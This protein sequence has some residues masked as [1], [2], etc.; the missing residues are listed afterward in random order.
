MNFWKNFWH[1]HSISGPWLPNGVR[2]NFRD[3]GTFSVAFFH[4]QCWK[5]AIF[6]LPVC[7][8]Y[9]PR[10]YTTSVDNGGD[11]FYQVWSW[12][13]HPLPTYSI[14]DDNT[15]CDLDLWP[16]G[17]EQLSYLAGHVID[18]LTKFEV[19]V[20]AHVQYHD[21]LLVGDVNV[22]S[23]S[24]SSTSTY[25]IALKKLNIW[26]HLQPFSATFLLCIHKKRLFVNFRY[27]FWHHRSI[28][29]PRFPHKVRNFSD[30]KTPLIFALYILKV[31]HIS[32]S[33]LFDLLT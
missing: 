23:Q 12:Y 27:K 20:S 26:S 29:T 17:L 32:T 1:Y 6:L 19:R 16:F 15:L 10:K 7:L 5:S 11:N 3:L 30:L 4:F 24:Y 31:H 18:P 25:R 2:K 21:L 28:P 22:L 9:W 13:D 33:S 8:T 14:L